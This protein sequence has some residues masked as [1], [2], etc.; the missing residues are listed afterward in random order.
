MHTASLP[1]RP[2]ETPLGLGVPTPG[3]IALGTLSQSS[4]SALVDA[5]IGAGVGW[6]IAPE[7]KKAPYIIGGAAATG[8]AG[9]LGAR[10]AP[11]GPVRLESVSKTKTLGDSLSRGSESRAQ[12]GEPQPSLPAETTESFFS[13]WSAVCNEWILI[14]V[15][16]MDAGKTP[17][18][19]EVTVEQ[20]RR[21][22]A[23][24]ESAFEAH[25]RIKRALHNSAPWSEVLPP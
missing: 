20:Y 16:M 25:A 19:Y 18:A 2:L 6:L 22:N 23:R 7:T 17:S 24:G 15:E 5:A 21:M 11:G 13:W 3:G 14:Q 12:G 10:R 8:L 1:M 9:I 4:G